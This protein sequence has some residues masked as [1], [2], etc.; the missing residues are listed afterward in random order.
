MSNTQR[1]ARPGLLT[2]LA[3][4]LIATSVFAQQAQS[5]KNNKT[6]N[7]SAIVATP[8]AS[9]TVAQPPASTGS[10]TEDIRDIR[11]PISIPS[12]W[13][14]LWIPLAAMAL[15]G[16]L[17]AGWRWYRLFAKA[18]ARTPFETALERLER[19]KTL[20]KPEQAREYSFAVSEIVRE[21]I[22]QRF[23]ER[24]A[25]RTTQEFLRDV[26][27]QPGAALA[28]HSSLLEEFLRHCDLAKF[29]RWQLDVPQME[30]MQESAHTFILGT[31]PQP[32]PPKD[33][34]ASRNG[35]TPH[36][37]PAPF[38]ELHPEGKR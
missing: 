2:L 6:A 32:E 4:C 14:W 37:A 23:G 29:G 7:P 27:N 28:R 21:Y 11:G 1:S 24:A 15:L 33:P 25:R 34:T 31:R 9:S 3:L 12:P 18:K 26:V 13:R 19:A 10:K 8:P 17:Y 20:M 16:L 38:R 35:S 36:A 30:S 22:E 5:P